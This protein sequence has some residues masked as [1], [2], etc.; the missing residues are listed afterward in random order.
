M[1]KLERKRA[2][3]S[4]SEEDGD[5][6]VQVKKK[7]KATSVASSG[8]VASGKDNEGNPFWE[9]SRMRRVGVSKFRNN[10][11]INIREYYENDGELKPGKKGISLSIEQYKALLKAIPAINAELRSQ[12]QPVDDVAAGEEGAEA[13]E[14]LPKK[15]KAK[16][17]VKKAN[18]EATSDEDSE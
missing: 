9:L 4:M 10:T 6:N 8:G 1:P 5:D 12:G 17:P 11:L 3:R 16:S 2:A 18:I 13:A 7:A 14:K 15:K